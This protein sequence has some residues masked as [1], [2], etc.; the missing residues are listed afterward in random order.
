MTCRQSDSVGHAIGP[1]RMSDNGDFVA[2]NAGGLAAKA[3]S[4][5]SND[6]IGDS[7]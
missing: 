4:A 5:C 2:D 3:G 7:S 6:G 1:A